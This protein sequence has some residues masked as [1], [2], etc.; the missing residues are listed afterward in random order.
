[1]AGIG[2]IPKG[3]YSRPTPD[4]FIEAGSSGGYH[5]PL[6]AALPRYEE[7]ALYNDATDGR[8]LYVYGMLT[9]ANDDATFSVVY[10]PSPVNGAVVGA[11]FPIVSDGATNPGLIYLY[12]ALAPL[13]IDAASGPFI[14]DWTNTFTFAPIV[15]SGPIAVLRPGAAL[16]FHNHATVSSG[17]TVSFWWT[18]LK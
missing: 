12:S 11:G 1:M 8:S 14:S 5:T 4:W 16:A 17:I 18:A 13:P 15:S 7:I 9:E 3:V 2:R 10:R 6:F